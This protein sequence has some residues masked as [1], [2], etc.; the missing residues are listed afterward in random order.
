MRIHA[1]FSLTILLLACATMWAELVARAD[2]QTKTGAGNSA[3]IALAKK[4]PLVL[5]AHDFLLEQASHIR[6]AKLRNETLDA[7]GNEDTCIRHRASL[8]DAQKDAIVQTLLAQGLVNPSDAAGIQG[9]TKAG[10]FPAVVDDGTACPRLPQP[11]I[12]A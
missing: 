6:D 2:D 10:V 9:G 5:S 4:S 8:S 1:R 12:S 3:A 11:F 7:L